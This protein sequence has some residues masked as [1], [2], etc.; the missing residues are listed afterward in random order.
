MLV[1][2]ER[3]V[4]LV[5]MGPGDS[6]GAK[7]SASAVGLKNFGLLDFGLVLCVQAKKHRFGGLWRPKMNQSTVGS[8]MRV[9]F[10]TRCK[11][12]RLRTNFAQARR[13]EIV[14]RAK[15]Q[16]YET[17]AASTPRSPFPLPP[18]VLFLVPPPLCSLQNSSL[19][20]PSSSSHRTAMAIHA[21]AGR[22]RP[23]PTS[24]R[25]PAGS[26]ARSLYPS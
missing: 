10:R 3:V 18:S 22:F 17:R 25:S 23:S 24:S 11:S 14:R 9:N 1:V 19:L 2:R 8:W 12:S 21:A 7:Q 16:G 6:K 20:P 13:E 26:S 4:V 5:W 15:F